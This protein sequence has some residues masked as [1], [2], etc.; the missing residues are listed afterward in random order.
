M[1]SAI[2]LGIITN[3]IA[4]SWMLQTKLILAV[5]PMMHKKGKIYFILSVTAGPNA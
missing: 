5:A 2:M 1:K 3:P 4:K